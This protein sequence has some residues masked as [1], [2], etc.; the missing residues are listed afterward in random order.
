M[1]AV[2]LHARTAVAGLLRHRRLGGDRAAQG[3]GDRPSRCSATATSGRPRTPWRWSRQTGCDGVVVGRG[4]LGRP[5]L[6]T[7]LAAAFAGSA[8]AGAAHPRRGDRD[9]A[10]AHRLPRRVLRRRVQ[11]LPRHP[12]AHRLVPQGLPGRL[13]VRHQ[14]A[15]VDTLAALDDLI[16]TLDLTPPWPGEPAE[17]Q[18]GR[19]GSPRHVAL[20]DGW[21]TARS[22]ARRPRRRRPGRA[23]RLGRLTP[24]RP[25]WQAR[26]MCRNI[27]TLH[28][29]EP[30]ATREEIHAAALQYVRK[31]SGSTRPSA[32]NAPAVERRWPPSRPRPRRCSSSW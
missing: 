13:H 2:A 32:A 25:P 16:A 22:W 23:V 27:R 4:C 19:A 30:P 28:N 12:Q 21:L 7:D 18:R 14:L 3:G 8:A 10:A 24:A 26:G 1:A 17:G 15:L 5:W 31:V 29:F 11:G 20:P 6:F 9:D